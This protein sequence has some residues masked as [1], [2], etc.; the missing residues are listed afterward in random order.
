MSRVVAEADK[1]TPNALSLKTLDWLHRRHAEWAE[2]PVGEEEAEALRTALKTLA[3]GYHAQ[4]ASL[5]DHEQELRPRASMYASGH[6]LRVHTHV[7][8]TKRLYDRFGGPE[9]AVKADVRR[10]Y[11]AR[12]QLPIKEQARMLRAT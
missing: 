12:G 7:P 5:P 6:R 8:E 11:E 2:T 10:R 1:L 3:D 9:K 4:D